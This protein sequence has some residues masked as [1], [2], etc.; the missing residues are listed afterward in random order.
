MAAPGIEPPAAVA[1]AVP[2]SLQL[3]G[4]IIKIIEYVFALV[5]S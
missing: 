3:T 2:P 4:N 5:I 1:S